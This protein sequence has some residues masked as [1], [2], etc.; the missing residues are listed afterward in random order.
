M[1]A[2][3]PSPASRSGGACCPRRGRSARTA[4]RRGTG[5]RP[6]RLQPVTT[7][8]SCIL[9]VDCRVM[10]SNQR[11][12]SGFSGPAGARTFAGMRP[13]PRALLALLALLLLAACGDSADQ[14]FAF[15]GMSPGMT[16][17]RFRTAAAAAGSTTIECEPFSAAGLTVDRLCVS[18]DTIQAMVRVSGAVDPNGGVVPY[19]VVREA[20]TA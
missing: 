8:V 18:P 3:C 7:S 9:L 6:A 20:I 12:R 10:D 4:A 13:L 14:P 17:E 16:F 11:W 19:V 5:Q 15:R 1:C 2:S